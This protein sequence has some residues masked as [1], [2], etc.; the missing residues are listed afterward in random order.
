MFSFDDYREII[1]L[2]NNLLSGC[3]MIINLPC[4]RA[5]SIVKIYSIL[6]AVRYRYVK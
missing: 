3:G 1:R 5:I 4:N 2:I 6:T